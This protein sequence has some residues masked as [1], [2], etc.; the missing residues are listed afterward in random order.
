[1]SHF[2]DV[3][4]LITHYKR[5]DSLQKL[6]QAFAA[7][8]ITF[9]GIVV[10]DDRSGD[11]YLPRLQELSA[12]YNFKLVTTPVNKGLANNINKGQDAVTTPLTLYVQEDFTP[13][14]GYNN[15]LQQ[16][17]S[18]L[19]TDKSIDMVRFYAYFTYPYLKHYKDDFYLMDFSPWYW[20]DRKFH[21]YSDHPHLRRS[22]FLSKFGR[23]REGIPSDKGEFMMALSFL[24]HKGKALIYKDPKALFT[25]ANTEAE[26]STVSRKSM[27]YTDN[28]LVTLPRFVYR[29]VKHTWQLAF[30][31]G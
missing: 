28:A 9:G 1:M 15:Y 18:Y 8:Q 14:N 12:Q 22:D 19:Q 16:A 20:G 2:P 21:V 29:V 25:Q 4:L 5:T 6:L 10:S 7:Q 3:T 31:K 30:Y 23:Y 27:S 13:N 24:K 26:P 11:E 17:V